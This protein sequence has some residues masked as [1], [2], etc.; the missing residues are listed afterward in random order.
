MCEKLVQEGSDKAQEVSGSTRDLLRYFRDQAMKDRRVPPFQDL[1]G[2]LPGP[3]DPK[4]V[5]LLKVLNGADFHVMEFI[6]AH[7]IS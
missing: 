4:L 5:S 3:M 1:W 2:P 6:R 7:Q